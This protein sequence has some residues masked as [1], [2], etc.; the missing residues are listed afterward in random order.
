MLGLLIALL[1]DELFPS[2]NDPDTVSGG[3]GVGLYPG[4]SPLPPY[5]VI[6]DAPSPETSSMKTNPIW[7]EVLHI[8]MQLGIRNA[9]VSN[10]KYR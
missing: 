7:R 4:G 8:Q 5:S 3:G 9:R 1:R 2:L 6:G 10:H